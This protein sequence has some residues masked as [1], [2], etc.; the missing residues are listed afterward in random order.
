MVLKRSQANDIPVSYTH[1]D[2]YK[3]QEFGFHKEYINALIND[4]E[5]LDYF[6][7]CLDD[8]C[9]PTQTVKWIA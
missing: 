7:T 4:K 1:L 3:R 8:G 6:L 9:N 5:T 2:V